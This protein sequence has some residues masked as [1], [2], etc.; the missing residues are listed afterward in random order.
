M[1]K[2]V[3]QLPLVALLLAFTVFVG[4]AAVQA[5]NTSSATMWVFD[6]ETADP[7]PTDPTNYKPIDPEQAG[8]CIGSTEVCIVS[9]P[10]TGNGPDLSDEDLQDAL[11]NGSYHPDIIRGDYSEN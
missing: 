2:L 9:A 3:K 4:K 6:P 11:Q 7:D 10:D 5:L 1:D 8:T